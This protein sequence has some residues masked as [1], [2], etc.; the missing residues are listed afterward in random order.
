MSEINKTAAAAAIVVSFA[1][2]IAMTGSEAAETP[3]PQRGYCLLH[4][5]GGADCSFTS[6]P[7]CEAI[8][9]DQ[10]GECYQDDGEVHLMAMRRPLFTRE[11]W[12]KLGNPAV[13]I[14]S[15]LGGL[16]GK[17]PGERNQILRLIRFNDHSYYEISLL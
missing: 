5:H 17:R 6:K 1:T 13:S 3:A 10:G 7:Q 9:F 15:F 16:L 4:N 11:R 8:A 12:W 14:A 2:L